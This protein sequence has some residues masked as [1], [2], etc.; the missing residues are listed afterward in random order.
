MKRSLPLLLAPLLLAG[1]LNQSTSYLVD[2]PNHAI[3]LRAEQEY[4]WNNDVIVRMVTTHLPDCQRLFPMTTVP[5][6]ELDVELY[7]A[8]ENVYSLRIGKQVMRVETASC[9]RLT[10]PTAAELGERLGAFKLNAD[11]KLVFE[12]AP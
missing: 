9:T 7:S 6:A 4:F 12:K 5:L 11:K 1:C 10:E 2:G 3:T 8:G